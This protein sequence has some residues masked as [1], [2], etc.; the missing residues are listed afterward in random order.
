MTTLLTPEITTVDELT[1]RCDRCS[2]AAKLEVKLASG[3]AN[4]VEPLGGG[5]IV[6]PRPGR[7]RRGLNRDRGL[8][9]RLTILL[10]IGHGA[11]LPSLAA[12]PSRRAVIG[13]V[14]SLRAGVTDRH[15]RAGETG[16]W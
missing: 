14:C 5:Q 13:R 16:R 8:G 9:R 6:G 3:P 2:A 4:R 11:L 10:L 12:R 1:E 15:P 7:R